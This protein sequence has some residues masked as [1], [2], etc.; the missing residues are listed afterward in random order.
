MISIFSN[1]STDCMSRPN[2]FLFFPLGGPLLLQL[3][4]VQVALVRPGNV[5]AIPATTVSTV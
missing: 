3:A 4:V 1:P 2:A 5:V